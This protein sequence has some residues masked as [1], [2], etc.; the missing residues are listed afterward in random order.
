MKPTLWTAMIGICCLIPACGTASEADRYREAMVRV[1]QADQQ[2]AAKRKQAAPSSAGLADVITATE[3][4]CTGLEQL[5]MS[6]C[7]ADFR[8][9][10]RHHIRA[11][12]DAV[13]AVRE[14]PDGFWEG[15]LIG[16]L[17]GLTGVVDGGYGR[18]SAAVKAAD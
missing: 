8:V 7:P 2:L 1:F 5:D 3:A 17:N 18:M 10:Y 4:Y 11:W 13:A 16:L 12:R 6:D 9:A 15:A 14:L